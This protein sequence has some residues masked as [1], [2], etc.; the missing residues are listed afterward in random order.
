MFLTGARVPSWPVDGQAAPTMFG[1][2]F[3][4]RHIMLE[5]RFSPEAVEARQ[6]ARWEEAGALNAPHHSAAPL[7]IQ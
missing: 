5:N 3:L 2:R 7:T 6:Y 4:Q 1:A